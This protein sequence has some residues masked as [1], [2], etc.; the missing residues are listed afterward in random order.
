ME[1]RYWE[2]DLDT[3]NYTD[4]QHS[5]DKRKLYGIVDENAG[6]IIGYALSE[7]F[8]EQIINALE[9][10]AETYRNEFE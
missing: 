5:I 2:I 3:V 8:A 10:M 9:F 6:G 7:E 1:P 4:L